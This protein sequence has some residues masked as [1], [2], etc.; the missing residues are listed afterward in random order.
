MVGSGTPISIRWR[1]PGSFEGFAKRTDAGQRQLLEL[2]ADGS[3]SGR[4][5][6]CGFS[7]V[8]FH[9]SPIIGALARDSKRQGSGL[10][11]WGNC[12]DHSRASAGNSSHHPRPN[13]A[14][15][16][17]HGRKRVA[18]GRKLTHSTSAGHFPIPP[19]AHH[20]AAPT[21]TGSRLLTRTIACHAAM[22]LLLY[23]LG[24]SPRSARFAARSRSSST[25]RLR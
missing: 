3:E 4:L 13:R 18:A 16:S 5:I 14:A 11:T 19:S 20:R 10:D 2:H 9:A 7:L 12:H 6:S 24:S 15:V 23:R 25:F 21:Q 17:G 22:L 1:V 8:P